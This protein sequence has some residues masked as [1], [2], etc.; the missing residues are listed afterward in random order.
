MSISYL[1]DPAICIEI[2]KHIVPLCPLLP[3]VILYIQYTYMDVMKASVH[4]PTV[5]LNLFEKVL[6]SGPSQEIYLEIG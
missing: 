3:E 1:I 6:S 2:R 5:F 4:L